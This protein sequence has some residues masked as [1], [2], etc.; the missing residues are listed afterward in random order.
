MPL[1]VPRPL[2]YLDDNKLAL[3]WRALNTERNTVSDLHRRSHYSD[4]TFLNQGLAIQS[5]MDDV[6]EEY[7]AR[8]QERR[9]DNK[10]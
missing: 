8:Y 6:E 5:I 1:K 9:H 3:L 2:S 4:R 7:E 10:I